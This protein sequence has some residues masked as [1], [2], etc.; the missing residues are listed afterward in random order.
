MTPTLL[1]ILAALKRDHAAERPNPTPEQ[2]PATPP[3]PT[4]APT[5]ATHIVGGAR[6]TPPQPCGH[7]DSPVFGPCDCRT[8]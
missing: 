1:T 7:P 4:P 2:Q 3:A 6:W 5:Y 8:T